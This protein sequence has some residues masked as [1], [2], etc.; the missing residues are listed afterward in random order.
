MSSSQF[1]VLAQIK[2]QLKIAAR[3]SQ[4]QNCWLSDKAW[5]EIL[6]HNFQLKLSPSNLKKAFTDD[7]VNTGIILFTNERH[8]KK[9]GIPKQVVFYYIATK[10]DNS[11]KSLHFRGIGRY[12][13]LS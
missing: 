10:P 6:E 1:G 5:I 12:I 9:K 13:S 4:Y 3:C 8:F 7:V 11:I 2:E